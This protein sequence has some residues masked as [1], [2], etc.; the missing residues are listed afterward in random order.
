MVTWLRGYVVTWLAG[1][2]VTWLGGWVVGWLGG[3][4]NAQRRVVTWL[5]GYVVSWLRGYVVGFLLPS[6]LPSLSPPSTLFPFL[7]SFFLNIYEFIYKVKREERR[8]KR[9]E[10]GE[11]VEG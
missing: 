8:G 9:E 6:S 2:V 1:Y 5:A 3:G 10:E 4:S 7:S 11:M